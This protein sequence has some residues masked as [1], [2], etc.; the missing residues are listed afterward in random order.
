MRKYLK[1][2]RRLLLITAVII[3]AFFGLLFIILF[4]QA[5]QSTNSMQS[6][7]VTNETK[8][9]GRNQGINRGN[10]LSEDCLQI[11]T[12]D[13]P[14]DQ[15][16]DNVK[17]ALDKAIIDE[18]KAYATYDAVL[19]KF[20]MTRPFSM[21]I[22]AEEQHISS[23]KSVYD[24]YGLEIPENTWV[25]TV[26]VPATLTAACQTGVDAELANVKLYKEELLPVVKNYSDITSVFTRLMNA[27]ETKHLPA[28][29]RCN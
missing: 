9:P 5:P 19:E 26:N 28:F 16:P 21:I 15:L 14:V 3:L 18:Y 1:R 27:S 7:S 23:L 17:N 8:M 24:K 6:T 12:V 11:D 25:G 10:C 4:T 13:Y 2:N 29:Q 22:R 20:G